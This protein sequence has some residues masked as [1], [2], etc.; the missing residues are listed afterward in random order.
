MAIN[1]L[2]SSTSNFNADKLPCM[3]F[4]ED[5][6]E[7]YWNAFIL[8]AQG[9]KIEAQRVI[10]SIDNAER[11]NALPGWCK[12]PFS[13]DDISN[14]YFILQFAYNP[15]A[16][17]KIRVFESIGL[18]GH[19]VYLNNV[20]P[21]H[22]KEVHTQQKYILEKLDALHATNKEELD[23]LFLKWAR[24]D[25]EE[26]TPFLFHEYRVNQIFGILQDLISVFI[27]DH[28]L[29]EKC[30]ADF[31]IMRLKKIPTQVEQIVELIEHQK[32][33]KIVP[34]QFAIKKTVNLIENLM[35]SNIKDNILY[36]YFEKQVKAVNIK[37][38]YEYLEKI[39]IILISDIYPALRILKKHCSKLIL[40]SHMNGVWA[41]PNGD[42]YYSYC[43]KKHTTTTLSAEEIHTLGCEQVHEIQEAIKKIFISMGEST[44]EENVATKL[45]DIIRQSHFC[46]KNNDEDREK[47]LT[48]L[49]DMWRRS[50]IY[51]Y[52]LF[53]IKPKKKLKIEAVPKEFQEGA[54]LAY[55]NAASIDGKRKGTFY[56][57]LRDMN[58]ISQCQ[59][60]SLTLHE[61]EP[62]HHFQRTLQQEMDI[63]NIR[64]YA[65]FSAYCEGWG[66]YCERLGY[67]HKFYSSVYQE[68]G[69]LQWELL[70]AA[71]LVV[72]TG[73]HYKRW[74]YEQ[75][76]AYMLKVTGLERAQVVTEVERYFVMPGQA[77]AYKIGQLKLLELRDKMKNLY[78]KSF[79]IQTFH[80]IIMNTGQI[81]L[82]L[83]EEVILKK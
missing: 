11:F 12:E 43:L 36:T 55:Y 76:L 34:P 37:N 21:A 65:S 10:Q 18:K 56:I 71:R 49:R 33:L 13:L 25:L 38:V 32:K 61:A 62:G 79:N 66:L 42:A 3:Y 6:T 19:N 52:P 78:Q 72:D 46:Y 17:S 1:S 30:D 83:L 22:I 70:R 29:E 26:R 8:N 75:A 77:C 50:C 35:T 4:S 5:Q 58:E 48:D 74:S 41:L 9:N 51:L 63:T 24:K 69:Y 2:C 59:L 54:P 27:K 14:Y 16:L 82:S 20:T 31:Y 81:P 44:S 68:L 28:I 40:T 23:Y 39:S 73:I 7:H 64:R 80:H 60:E 53:S 57:N 67:E 47:C 45:S 15:Q